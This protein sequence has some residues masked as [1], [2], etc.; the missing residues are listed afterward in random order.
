MPLKAGIYEQYFELQEKYEAIFG[1]N[2]VILMEVGNFHQTY[3]RKTKSGEFIGKAREVSEITGC[4]L[5]KP[6]SKKEFSYENPYM[7]GFNSAS[8]DKFTTML[9][10]EGYKVVRVDQLPDSDPNQKH[11]DRAVVDVSNTISSLGTDSQKNTGIC[12]IIIEF[13]PTLWTKYKKRDILTSRH[14]DHIKIM[15]GLSFID[16][17]TGR[18]IIC[19]TYSN[20]INPIKPLQEL[21]RFLATYTPGELVIHI[22]GLN[23]TS[24]DNYME[25][26]RRELDLERYMR[27]LVKYDEIEKDF[28]SADYHEKFLSKIFKKSVSYPQDVMENL[29][30]AQLMYGTISYVV[31]LQYC[32]HHNDKLIENLSK[33]QTTWLDEEEHLQLVHN[34]VEQLHIVPIIGQKTRKHRRNNNR[35]TKA[36]STANCVYAVLDHTKTRLGKQYLYSMLTNPLTSAEKLVWYYDMIE[37]FINNNNMLKEIRQLLSEVGDIE[38]LHRKISIKPL[39]PAE[40]ACLLRSYMTIHQLQTK[41]QDDEQFNDLLLPKK[42]YKT[43]K[44]ILDELLSVIDLD[45]LSKTDLTP[46]YLASCKCY[47]RKGVCKNV[48]NWRKSIRKAK[49]NLGELVEQMCKI[50]RPKSTKSKNKDVNYVHLQLTGEVDYIVPYIH[51][52]ADKGKRLQK[53]QKSGELEMDPDDPIQL[54]PYKKTKVYVKTNLIKE[55]CSNLY[56]NTIA[57]E[58]FLL[59]LYKSII[60]DIDSKRD[61]FRP[62][63]HFVRILDFVS[64]GAYVARKYK[65]VKPEIDDSSDNSYI[66]AKDIRHPLV[67]RIIPTEYVVNDLKLGEDPKGILLYGLNYSGKST[68]TRAT[69]VIVVMAQAGLWVPASSMKYRPYKKIM[70]RLTSPDDMLRSQSFFTGEMLE[71]RT[72]LRH[73]DN[74]SLVL[75]DELTKGTEIVSGSSLTI[76]SILTLI[77]RN[78]SFIFSTHIHNLLE[79]SF[80]KGIKQGDLK[81]G[82]LTTTY[83]ETEDIIV[84]DRKLEDGPGSDMYGIEVAKSLHLDEEFIKLACKIR[85]E[86]A[87]ISPVVHTMKK[88]KYNS[89]VYIDECIL[90]G[91]EKELQTHHMKEQHTAD[92]HGFIGSLHKNKKGNLAVL[93]AKCHRKLHKEGKKIVARETIGKRL[94]YQVVDED[95]HDD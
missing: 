41:L 45:S 82:H 28:L 3:A 36:S 68:Y 51:T 87:D 48:D 31:L 7:C 56:T 19:E 85:M 54:E 9:E 37:L 46:G 67:E 20:D 90:C 92:D 76:A 21:Y 33:P 40:L 8:W 10:E 17:S 62:L 73:A 43:M 84:Y 93:C 71:L 14:F 2:T 25:Y 63:N 11:K 94:I 69:G 58:Q 52:S 16:I 47:V 5:T 95:S 72:I 78:T 13:P 61:I 81:V 26:L 18:N 12:C 66:D 74:Y 1:P 32:Y 86:I 65:Y 49:E 59:E 64:N 60:N 91:S 57:L 75:G 38:K 15:C 4:K 6:D 80:M 44:T 77:D 24:K 53:A 50:L 34:T 55:Y 79:T 30:I 39:S 83:D 88:S 70:T 27:L 35:S 89:D 42:T 23:N 29:G 22:I